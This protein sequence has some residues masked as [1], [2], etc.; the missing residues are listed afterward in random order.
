MSDKCQTEEPKGDFRKPEIYCKKG[1]FKTIK[2]K[3]LSKSSIECFHKGFITIIL[4]KKNG[5]KVLFL[6]GMFIEL[7]VLYFVVGYHQ[8]HAQIRFILR[9]T[10]GKWYLQEIYWDDWKCEPFGESGK[11]SRSQNENLAKQGSL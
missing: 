1:H 8:N 10:R 9:H 4:C 3:L 5:I 6:E 7:N 11:A 2:R